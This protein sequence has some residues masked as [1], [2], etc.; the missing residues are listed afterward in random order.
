MNMMNCRFCGLKR[1]RTSPIPQLD[2]E[3]WVF[4][5]GSRPGAWVRTRPAPSQSDN[6]PSARYAHQVVYDTRTHTAYLHG[7]NAGRLLESGA[8]GDNVH[9]NDA[10]AEQRLDDFWSMSLLR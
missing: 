1:T 9:G 4:R 3:H 5:Y 7:G 10:L 8:L 6:A 2:G